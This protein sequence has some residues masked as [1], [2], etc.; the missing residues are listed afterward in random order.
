MSLAVNAFLQ[1]VF[2]NT[3]K[4][5]YSFNYVRLFLLLR[6]GRLPNKAKQDALYCKDGL[7]PETT[8]GIVDFLLSDR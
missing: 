6:K 8:T 5:T 1:N 4:Q 3:L 2:K 7:C